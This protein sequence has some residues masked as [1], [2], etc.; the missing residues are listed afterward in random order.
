MNPTIALWAGNS[1]LAIFSGLVLP[2]IIKH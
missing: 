2:S 1:L